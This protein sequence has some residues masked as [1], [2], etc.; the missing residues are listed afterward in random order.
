MDLN[1]SERLKT[2]GCLELKGFVLVGVVMHI[3]LVLHLYCR[4][5]SHRPATQAQKLTDRQTGNPNVFRNGTPEARDLAIMNLF[6]N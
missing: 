4:A 6:H 1:G 2:V 3:G 5:G